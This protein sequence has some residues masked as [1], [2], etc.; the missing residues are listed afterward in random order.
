MPRLR[1]K[2]GTQHIEGAAEISEYI[3]CN[4]KKSKPRIHHLV[5]ENK[6]RYRKKCKDLA[7]YKRQRRN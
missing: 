1:R 5:C 2:N 4:K 3:L 7:A 6:C